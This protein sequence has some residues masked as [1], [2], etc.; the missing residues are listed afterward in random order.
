MT[1]TTT[2]PS[3][4]ILETSLGN[5][6]IALDYSAAPQTSENFAKLAGAG[7]YNNL[8]FHRIIPG[9]VIQGGD[10]KGDG[11][12]G[13]GYTVPAEIKLSHKRGSIAMARLGDEVN[14]NRASSG[15]QFY[16]ALQ[17]LSQL[18][19]QYTVFGRVVSGMDVVDKIA[20]VKTDSSDK[21]LEPVKIIKASVAN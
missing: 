11:T 21:P 13:P 14:P 1:D 17:D 19:G 12:G 5:I 10:P 18:D 2:K 4:V 9:F 16:I 7:F 6:E 20:A 8:T 15:S 3:K